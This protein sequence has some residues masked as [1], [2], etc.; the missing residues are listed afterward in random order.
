ME[1]HQVIVAVLIAVTGWVV[2]HLLYIRAQNKNFINTVINNARLEIMKSIRDYE[3]WLIAIGSAINV[4]PLNTT[5]EEKNIAPVD[6][7]IKLIEL[8]SLFYKNAGAYNWL[9]SLEEY[10]I[11]FP[12]IRECRMGLF[13]RQKAIQDYLHDFID[14]LSIN[15]GPEKANER[16]KVIEKAV[17]NVAIIFDQ[18]G[19]LQD[20]RIIL[21]D[22]CLGSITKNKIPERDLKDHP[23]TVRIIKGKN[24]VFKIYDPKIKPESST[25]A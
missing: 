12:R 18:V 2:T 10:D 17:E 9:Y 19:L 24:G 11:L 13:Q 6:W 15:L 16:K 7:V 8:N 21:Q 5:L 22:I 4:L 25:D 1:T 14:N 20:L 3:D 23:T